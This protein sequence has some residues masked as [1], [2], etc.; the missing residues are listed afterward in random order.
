MRWNV[1]VN[2]WKSLGVMPYRTAKYLSDRPRTVAR[3]VGKF[4]QGRVSNSDEQRSERP[5]SVLTDLTRGVIEHLMH[6]DRRW[7]LLELE[8]VSGIEKRTTNSSAC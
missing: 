8:R 4:Q 5:L 1:T 3:W 2:L 6:E 7:M